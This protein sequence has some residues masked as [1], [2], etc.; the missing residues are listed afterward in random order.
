MGIDFKLEINYVNRYEPVGDE[1]PEELEN[2]KV[3]FRS[4]AC[5]IHLGNL[6]EF[7]VL[8]QTGSEYAGEKEINFREVIDLLE[9]CSGVNCRLARHALMWY[10]LEQ[11]E[12]QCIVHYS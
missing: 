2:G 12:I 11:I 1:K 4:P 10:D 3:V 5:E 7:R 6:R 9:N 8:F